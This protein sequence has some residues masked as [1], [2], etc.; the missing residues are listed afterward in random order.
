MGLGTGFGGI[1]CDP[2]EP[3]GSVDLK[4]LSNKTSLL[5]A[6]ASARHVGDLHVLTCTSLAPGNFKVTSATL[7]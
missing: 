4:I 7:R 2:F 3:L 1:V 5:M 6:L